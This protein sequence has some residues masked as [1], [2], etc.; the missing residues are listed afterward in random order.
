VL[1]QLQTALIISVTFIWTHPWVGVNGLWYYL[2]SNHPIRVLPLNELKYPTHQPVIS[3]FRYWQY[4]ANNIHSIHGLNLT[5]V[6][7]TACLFVMMKPISQLPEF[8]SITLPR[9]IRIFFGKFP[10][11]KG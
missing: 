3:N 4:L 2:T 5:E 7:L 1:K 8:H 9:Y 10:F 6:V 11:G